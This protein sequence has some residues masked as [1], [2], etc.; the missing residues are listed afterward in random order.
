MWGCVV[1]RGPRA[2]NEVGRDCVLERVTGW[3]GSAIRVGW[4][5]SLAHV[6]PRAAGRM[7]QARGALLQTN[8]VSKHVEEKEDSFHLCP[9]RAAPVQAVCHSSSSKGTGE[10]SS[11][12]YEVGSWVCCAPGVQWVLGGLEA[13][14]HLRL[15]IVHAPHALS[16]N[17]EVRSCLQL[18][19]S[20]AWWFRAVLMPLL[21]MF[22]TPP[23]HA[24]ILPHPQRRLKSA[25]STQ[26]RSFIYHSSAEALQARR[27]GVAASM[28]ISRAKELCPHLIV[29]PYDFAKYEAATEQVGGW[30]G[31]C[32]CMEGGT[33]EGE[34]WPHAHSYQFGYA[35]AAPATFLLC[36][37]TTF[38]T[39][40]PRFYVILG[41]PHGAGVPRYAQVQRL[42][43]AH[44][45][46]RGVCGHHR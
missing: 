18:L 17:H 35:H 45:L 5:H 39:E 28:F 20:W 27:Y 15:L 42:R 43:A 41:P 19:G 8:A 10:V 36:H 12:N 16:A 7:Q 33:L 38:E 44:Q 34:D 13:C 9:A 30:W 2:W 25:P 40:Y 22:V 11:A 31:T 4:G 14:I 23:P 26:F 1:V 32:R 46:R 29:V 3:A 6:P 24:I 37:C 21:A